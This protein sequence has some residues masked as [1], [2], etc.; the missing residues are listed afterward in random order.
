[1]KILVTGAGGLLGLNLALEL[2][3]NHQTV[4][5]DRKDLF[6]PDGIQAV[7]AD[8]LAENSLNALLDE[9][10]PDAVIHCAALANV[11]ACESDPAFSHQ[12]NSFCLMRIQFLNT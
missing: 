9:T 1:M 6:L 12:I 5:T 8:L 10:E 2:S 4:A 7:Q 3:K 11:D